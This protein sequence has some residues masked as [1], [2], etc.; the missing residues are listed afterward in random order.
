MCVIDLTLLAS[1]DKNV[2]TGGQPEEEGRQYAEGDNGRGG[3]RE[4]KVTGCRID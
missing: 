2:H 4:R 1:A 3:D